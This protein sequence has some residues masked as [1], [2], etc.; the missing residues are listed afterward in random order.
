MGVIYTLLN[1]VTC[2]V[3]CAK[4]PGLWRSVCPETVV[5]GINGFLFDRSG[6]RRQLL[7]AGRGAVQR[8]VER[9]RLLVVRHVSRRRGVSAAARRLPRKRHVSQHVRVVRL[10]VQPRL[11]RKREG[12]VQQNVRTQNLSFR[13]A[14]YC[15]HLLQATDQYVCDICSFSRCRCY[16]ECVHGVCS[17]APQF[18]C[19]CTV[20][21]MGVDCS[22]NC[23]CNN[24]ST[25]VTGTVVAKSAFTKPCRH[26]LRTFR[27]PIWQQNRSLHQVWACATNVN[28]GQPEN[29]ASFAKQGRTAKLQPEKVRTGASLTAGP[30]GPQG[31]YPPS[32][33]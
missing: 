28:I 4:S 31:A 12:H 8:V 14:C 5:S 18:V 11:H 23:G 22:T 19:N 3:V 33:L 26:G 29:I 7:G 16:H 27:G 20:G 10:R 21:W 24:H 32:H 25:C 2:S 17:E 1:T 13:V 15:F 9:S 30:G 6:D